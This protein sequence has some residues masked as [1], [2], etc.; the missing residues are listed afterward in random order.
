MKQG[1]AKD[2]VHLC[3]QHPLLIAVA[4]SALKATGAREVQW[5]QFILHFEANMSRRPPADVYRHHLQAAL[6][7]CL[8]TLTADARSLFMS[9]GGQPSSYVVLVRSVNECSG[10][11]CSALYTADLP[12]DMPC[13]CAA[14]FGQGGPSM[15]L[16]GKRI[17]EC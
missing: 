17:C 9:F 8:D 10:N 13:W 2:V 16:V 11:I 14:N 6:D 7:M 12:N 4:G 3:R 1:V 15:G 5:R